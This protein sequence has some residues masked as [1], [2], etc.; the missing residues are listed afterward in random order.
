M[1]VGIIPGS[2]Q[3]SAS[4]G[5]ASWLRAHDVALMVSAPSVDRVLLLRAGDGDGIDVASHGLPRPMGMARDASTLWI[6]CAT[7]VWRFEDAR[8]GRGAGQLLARAQLMTG[9]LD[10]HDL[11]IDVDHQPLLA[12]TTYSCVGALDPTRSFAARWTPPFI[13]ALAAEDRCHL[14]GLACDGQGL[15]YVTAFAPSD[16]REGW[17]T[18][19]DQG[20]VFDVREREVILSGLVLPHSPRIHDGQL[21]LLEA[22]SGALLR[23]DDRGQL[24]RLVQLPGFVRGLTFVGG[25]PL[26]TVS[27]PRRLGAFANL[28]L[29]TLAEPARCGLRVLSEDGLAVLHGLDLPAPFDELYD[30]IAVPGAATRFEGVST[31][32]ARRT[33]VLD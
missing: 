27:Q 10:V 11:A 23:V 7:C 1:M 3:A 25:H 20:L 14:N 21:W 6:A 12:V 32:V 15:R 19:N 17:R 26:V 13:T 28:P 33:V 29:H 4:A 31:D 16:E 18:K 30:V 22:G 2:I 5:L 9:D 24:E 8:R